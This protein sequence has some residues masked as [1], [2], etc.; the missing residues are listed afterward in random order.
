MKY[1]RLEPRQFHLAESD[2]D[3]MNATIVDRGVLYRVAIG[4]KLALAMAEKLTGW[5]RRRQ[6]EREI[7]GRDAMWLAS[8]ITGEGGDHG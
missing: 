4:E 6:S 5:V 7:A 8:R 3:V 1:R 2:G